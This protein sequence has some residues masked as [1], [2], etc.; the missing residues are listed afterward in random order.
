MNKKLLIAIGSGSLILLLSVFFMFGRQKFVQQKSPVQRIY[1]TDDAFAALKEDGSVI[2]WGDKQTGGDS[3]SVAA[4]L[5]R[6]N[7]KNNQNF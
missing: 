2:T 6:A 4:H 7:R 5:K 3:S 1:S